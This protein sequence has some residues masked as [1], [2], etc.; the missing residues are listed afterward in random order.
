MPPFQTGQS[1]NPAGRPKGTRNA[2]ILAVD[3]LL[4]SEAEALTRK[5]IDLALAGDT[6]ALKLCLERLAPPVRTRPIHIDLP[7]AATAADVDHGMTVLLH[8][9]AAGDVTPAE[10]QSLAQI[11]EIKRKSIETTAIEE[12]LAQL[13]AINTPKGLDHVREK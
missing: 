11:F 12:R 13:E 10:A 1:G 7:E 6:T 2:A 4:A 9:T 5:A 3:R 8:A